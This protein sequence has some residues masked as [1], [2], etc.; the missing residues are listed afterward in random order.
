MHRSESVRKA[1]SS[2]S[3]AKPI[4]D[5]CLFYERRNYEADDTAEDND[6]EEE[7]ETSNN[8]S[9]SEEYRHAEQ[10]DAS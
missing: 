2:S 5:N 10:N 3:T 7:Q 1:N 9:H 6:V 4:G 8:E